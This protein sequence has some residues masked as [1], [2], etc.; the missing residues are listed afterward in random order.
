MSADPSLEAEALA[1]PI[2][3]LFGGQILEGALFPYPEPSADERET[4][5]AFLDSLRSFAKDRIDPARLDREKR[6]SPEVVRGL[7]DLGSSVSRS[8]AYGATAS[9]LRL[10]RVMEEVG[11]TT[12]LSGSDRRPPVHRD[13]APSSTGGGSRRSGGFRRSRRRVASRRSR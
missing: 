7:A 8:P 2:K 6:I 9:P 11:S 4:V 12:P 10:L 5:S 13:E 3:G 1:S